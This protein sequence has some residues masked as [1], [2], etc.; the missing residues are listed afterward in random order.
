MKRVYNKL[1]RD[2]IPEIIEAKGQRA[3]Y[4]VLADAEYWEYLLKK[5]QEE[6]REVAEAVSIEEQKAELADKLEVLRAMAEYRGFSLQ[7][8]IVAAD[9]KAEAR[10]GFEKRI[11]LIEV[12]KSHEQ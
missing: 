7:D 10:G 9:K 2:R 1:V 6:L 4:S 3:V 5:D 11:F 8:I 12:E